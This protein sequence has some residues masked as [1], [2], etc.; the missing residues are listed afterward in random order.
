MQQFV[1]PQFID[2]ETK[3]IGPISA[4]QFI[5]VLVSGG[6]IFLWFQI[7]AMVLFIPLAFITGA[8]GGV[9][10]FGKV[11]GQMMHY[12]LLNLIQTIRRPTLRLWKRTA[13][14]EL[15]LLDEEETVQIQQKAQVTESR[16]ASM[17]LM[18]DTGGAYAPDDVTIQRQKKMKS[19]KQQATTEQQPM[20]QTE[21]RGSN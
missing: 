14:E 19:R 3:I 9:L 16:L 6:L 12:F 5:I 1:V 20:Q 2:V 21:D 8:V 18:V 11:N 15:A 10:A 17:S 7:F 4:R 13:Y